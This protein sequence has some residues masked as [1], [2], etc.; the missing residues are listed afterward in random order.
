MLASYLIICF[1]LPHCCLSV[2]VPCNLDVRN[3]WLKQVLKLPV[4]CF[5]I[6]Q[7][8]LLPLFINIWPNIKKLT[9]KNIC[10]YYCIF[11]VIEKLYFNVTYKKYNHVLYIT[12]YC[13]GRHHKYVWGWFELLFCYWVQRDTYL[14]YKFK[15]IATCRLPRRPEW[16]LESY[17]VMT[18]FDDMT[19]PW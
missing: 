9:S 6:K 16:H 15:T 2:Y 10:S 3:N 17:Q 8:H 13:G 1:I 19:W 7:L 18:T 4:Y 14:Y 11:K 5:I 12:V